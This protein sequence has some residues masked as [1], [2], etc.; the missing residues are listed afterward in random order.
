LYGR[1]RLSFRVDAD[2]GLPE[3]GNGALECQAAKQARLPSQGNIALFQQLYIC[4]I[5]RGAK[6]IYL[7][8][9]RTG[10]CMASLGSPRKP[11]GGKSASSGP[12]DKELRKTGIDL[13]GD[14]LWGSHFCLF[15]ETKQDLLDTLLPY[16]RAGLESHEFCVWVVSEP[17]TLDEVCDALRQDVLDFDRY[18]SE[19]SIEI[20]SGRE[21]YLEGDAVSPKRIID[22][23]I[24]KL[25]HALNNGFEGIRVS[26]NAFWLASKHY[27]DFCIYER[28]VGQ[29]FDG[30][31]ITALCTYPL[32][33][34]GA[35]DLLDVARAHQFTFARRKGEWELIEFPERNHAKRTG[36]LTGR[37]REVLTWVAQGK[38]AW[39][40]GEI[41]GIVKRT[42]DE[43]AASAFRKLGAVNR[44]QA[45]AIAIRDRLI[46]G[47]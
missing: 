26:G 4:T 21:W 41:L 43:H 19:G 23:W 18:L 37:E 17:L 44:A 12:T 20:H 6:E 28:D 31:L 30:K 25:R 47:H 29:A 24:D 33:A 42:V 22:G 45:V 8:V 34:S 40:I 38:S 10:D 36:P 32:T 14:M 3:I 5:R 35:T 1:A 46:E 9:Q 15:Y 13:L 7:C 16:F 39:E 11:G 2:L 27:E